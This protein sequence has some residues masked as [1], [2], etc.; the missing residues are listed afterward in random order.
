MGVVTSD[1][2]ARRQAKGPSVRLFARDGLSRPGR[3]PAAT[4]VGQFGVAT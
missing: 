3:I 4:P 2:G 1:P